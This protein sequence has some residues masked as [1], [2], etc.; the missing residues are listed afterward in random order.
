MNPPK[1]NV[2]SELPIYVLIE[3][4]SCSGVHVAYE[5]TKD[6]TSFMW[7]M[8]CRCKTLFKTALNFILIISRSTVFE[9]RVKITLT[10]YPDLN[11][12]CSQYFCHTPF[13]GGNLNGSLNR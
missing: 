3:V 4:Q 7:V 12:E 5:D 2:K 13:Q 11:Y 9:H 8:V 1:Y 6:V 10:L